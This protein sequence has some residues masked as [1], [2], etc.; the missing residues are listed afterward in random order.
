MVILALL[1]E[2]TRSAL[3]FVMIVDRDMSES[4]RLLLYGLSSL[5]GSG[6]VQPAT[7]SG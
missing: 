4:A 6:L 7:Q 3:G 1:L 5:A 2:F